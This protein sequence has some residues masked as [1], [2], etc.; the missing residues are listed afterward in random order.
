M[1]VRRRFFLY[2]KAFLFNGICSKPE[3]LRQSLSP[4]DRDKYDIYV[5]EVFKR[6]GLNISL[7]DNKKTDRL[8]AGALMSTIA[9]R[10][11][12]E[13]FREKGIVPQ[14]G[15][16][17]SSGLV[18]ACACFSSISYDVSYD[19]IFCNRNTVLAL[20]QNDKHFDMGVIIGMDGNDISEIIQ[21]TGE[22][23]NVVIGSVNSRI[24][25]MIT[26]RE[27]SVA[28][29]LEAATNEGALKAIKMNVGMA[30]HTPLIEPYASA[31][32]KLVSEVDYKDPEYPIVSVFTN[33]PMMTAEEIREEQIKDIITPM[34]WDLSIAKME[35]LGV[36][37][38][39]DTSAD[40]AIKKF[41][42]LKKRS[43]KIYTYADL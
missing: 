20:E 8:V 10:V 36:T 2:N 26:G 34:R 43:S 1:F 37:E 29:V 40:G 30:Y 41:S 24:C 7:I 25:S 5:E 14:I 39:Y 38:F 22:S 15:C 9:D 3:K 18:G 16:G 31:Y 35:E 27:P 28:R 6:Y 42:R 23:E 17:Y 19:I 12:Y 13:A 33:E 11:V 32:Q 21:S 4:A